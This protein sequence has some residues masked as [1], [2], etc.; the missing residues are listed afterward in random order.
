MLTYL[1]LGVLGLS[2]L[3]TIILAIFMLMDA[4]S[5]ANRDDFASRMT[6]AVDKTANANGLWTRQLRI[7][8]VIFLIA[9]LLLAVGAV[10]IMQD[11]RSNTWTW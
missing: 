3:G 1:I 7:S 11:Y 10:Y 4:R 2:A 6:K 5:A 8:A 9:L